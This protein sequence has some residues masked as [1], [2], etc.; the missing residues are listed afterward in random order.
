MSSAPRPSL[1]SKRRALRGHIRQQLDLLDRLPDPLL[2]VTSR[3]GKIKWANRAAHEALGPDLFDRKLGDVLGAKPLKTALRT[4]KTGPETAVEVLVQPSTQRGRD[5]RARLVRLET[6]SPVGARILVTLSDVTEVLRSQTQRTDFI[7]HASH[8][9]KTPV[10]ALSGLIE[11]LERDPSALPTF[12]SLM[13]KETARM[14]ALT[15][16]LL[17]LA[18]TEMQ[19]DTPPE[20]RVVVEPLIAQTL[21]TLAQAVQKRRQIVR[22][23]TPKTTAQVRGDPVALGTALTNLLHNAITYSPEGGTIEV[24][25][26]LDDREVWIRIRD[27]GPG[28][29]TKHLPRLTERFYRA[30]AGR[31][32]K[33]G[34]TGL[35]LAIVKHILL[36]H[37]GRLLID[38]TPGRGSCFTL[39]LPLYVEPT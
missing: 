7:A 34:G 32:A 33:H 37:Q 25:T 8:E 10:A 12:L 1:A 19:T 16:G 3:K 24:D 2:Q 23:Q 30:D 29:A 21:D 26:Q 15:G 31:D 36:R 27:Q 13:A 20:D 35:G 9:L 5:F 28:I 4:L 38:S 17:D 11:T 6:K 22:T 39:V 14:R 18:K